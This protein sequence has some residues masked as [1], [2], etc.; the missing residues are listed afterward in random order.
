MFLVS[1][2]IAASAAVNSSGYFK[3]DL[4]LRQYCLDGKGLRANVALLLSHI[5]IYG[6]PT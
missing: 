2:A 4:G 6:F 1:L 3:L 5:L